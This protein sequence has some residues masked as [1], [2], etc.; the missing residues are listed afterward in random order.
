MNPAGFV[1]APSSNVFVQLRA[2]TGT[3]ITQGRD[4]GR[5]VRRRLDY[6][7]GLSTEALRLVQ[8]LLGGVWR[9]QAGPRALPIGVDFSWVDDLYLAVAHARREEA[10]E[11][12][13]EKVDDLLHSNKMRECNDLLRAID[14]R[15]LDSYMMVV[16][17]SV[18]RA[19]TDHLPYRSFMVERIR[20]II[21]E[22]DPKKAD[23]LLANL[24]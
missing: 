11:L 10:G 14:L 18:T 6:L 23:R 15:R 2:L 21:A 4:L 13:F 17:M 16:L 7:V 19:A 8:A 5:D 24:A 22:T 12:I 1:F 3:S 9:N 20:E